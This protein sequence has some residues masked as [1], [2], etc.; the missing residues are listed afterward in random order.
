[1]SKNNRKAILLKGSWPDI[2]ADLD[3]LEKQRTLAVERTRFIE[4]QQNDLMA[5][6]KEITKTLWERLTNKLAEKGLLKNYD[7]KTQNLHWDFGAGVLFMEDRE[8]DNGMPD[9]LK[10]LLGVD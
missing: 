9:F 3:E 10:R 7:D 8:K 6:H 2:D 1:M 4:K 5:S